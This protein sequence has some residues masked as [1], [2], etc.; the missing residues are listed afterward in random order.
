M[1][2]PSEVAVNCA[3]LQVVRWEGS[4][5]NSRESSGPAMVKLTKSSRSWHTFGSH[6]Q[7]CK[8]YLSVFLVTN[9]SLVIN[10]RNNLLRYLGSAGRTVRFGQ[11][12]GEVGV[13]LAAHGAAAHRD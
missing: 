1:A 2:T 11:A 8:E 12:A 5:S 13:V 6:L 10:Y 4:P 7:I 3:V 9:V